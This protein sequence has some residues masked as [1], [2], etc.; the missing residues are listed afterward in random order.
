M[1][2]NLSNHIHRLWS[3][4]QLS[5]AAVYGEVWDMPFPNVPAHADET[6]ISSTA[7]ALCRD[8]LERRPE[9]VLV[10]GEMSLTYSVVHT[11]RKNNITVLCAASE[12]CCE[13]TLD[14]DGSTVRRSVFK[15]VCF[16]KYI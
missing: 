10:Q 13:S 1:L 9:A 14:A 11:L 6:W 3:A 15:F 12:R 2:I 4:E 8:I 5:A 16:R 7:D